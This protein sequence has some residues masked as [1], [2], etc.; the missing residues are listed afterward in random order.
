MKRPPYL[1]PLL[2]VGWAAIIECSPA[3]ADFIQV[4]TSP[5]L[6]FEFA[7]TGIQPAPQPLTMPILI[8]G[9][10]NVFHLGNYEPA[11]SGQTK[12]ITRDSLP[13]GEWDAGVAAIKALNNS[14]QGTGWFWFGIEP[15]LNTSSPGQTSYRPSNSFGLYNLQYI[16]I[17]PESPYDVW[18]DNG[19]TYRCAAMC[20]QFG[21]LIPEPCSLV[22]F[23]V[24]VSALG[25]VT[26][27]WGRSRRVILIG[28]RDCGKLTPV[29]SPAADLLAHLNQW[30]YLR[31]PCPH[32]PPHRFRR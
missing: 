1:I 8:G 30:G 20:L 27:R 6:L 12:T 21:W 31:P 9:D 29:D 25:C 17:A 32:R 15:A 3:A 5:Q 19:N 2:A 24:A 28:T 22:L 26:P 11:D 7:E 4:S 10:V 13:P 14:S 23:F 18:Y 16:N